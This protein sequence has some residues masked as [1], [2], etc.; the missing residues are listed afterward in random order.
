MPPPPRPEKVPSLRN[1]NH[2]LLDPF[3]R[4]LLAIF[5]FSFLNLKIHHRMTKIHFLIK[6]TAYIMSKCKYSKKMPEQTRVSKVD[7]RVLF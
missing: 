5:V 4:F 3:L 6:F 1:L 2:L 7:F